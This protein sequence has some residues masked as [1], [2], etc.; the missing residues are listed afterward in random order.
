MTR[1]A[2]RNHAHIKYLHVIRFL[3]FWGAFQLCADGSR[4]G[5]SRILLWYAAVQT[6]ARFNTKRKEK[7]NT[8]CGEYQQAKVTRGPAT[9]TPPAPA[10]T[11]R[12]LP[13]YNLRYLGDSK[14]DSAAYSRANASKLRQHTARGYSCDMLNAGEYPTTRSFINFDL[15]GRFQRSKARTDTP[16]LPLPSLLLRLL[17]T[18]VSPTSLGCLSLLLLLLLCLLL[19]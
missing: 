6:R 18:R 14:L 5:P 10:R 15:F 7:E 16:F 9:V 19:A 4:Q 13:L 3:D 8:R 2:S 1:I 11:S 12:R 17:V